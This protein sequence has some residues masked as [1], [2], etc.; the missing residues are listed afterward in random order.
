MTEPNSHP[1]WRPWRPLLTGEAAR[2][3]NAA[4]DAIAAELAASPES[5]KFRPPEGGGHFSLA[6][7]QA[8]IALFF[9]YLHFAR[10]DEGH[11]ETAMAFLEQAIEGTGEIAVSAGLYSGFAGVAWTLEHL[12]GRLFDP[13]GEDPGEEIATALQGLLG[14]SPWQGDYDL[15]SGLVGFGAYAL[16]RLPRPG[17]RECLEEI[18]SRLSELAESRETGTPPATGISWHTP[19]ERVGETQ[20]ELFPEGYYNLGVAHGV[21]GVI[22]L[23]GEVEAVGL[24]AAVTA[25]ARRLR[26]GA[27][28]WVASQQLP[29]G[30]NSL[31]PY[32]A[33]PGLTPTPSR[34]AWCYGDL[35]IAA[36]HLAAARAAR[37][38]RLETEAL[39]VARH[40]AARP[41]ESAGVV[42]AGLCHGAAGVGHLFNRLY[43]ASGEA[44]LRDAA[45]GWFERTLA[46]RGA[47]GIGGFR[48]WVPLDPDRTGE[49]GWATDP[50][51]LTG[52]AGIGLA[53]LAATT[54]VEPDWD[55]VL[56]T[57]IRG[58]SGRQE[59]T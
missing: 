5:A 3:A 35:G 56:L 33:A 38:P 2:A 12:Q 24:A 39:A 43:Q 52:S 34:L 29:A 7:G 13:D 42:D 50:G 16:E 15:I 59:E 26:E 58:A 46:L 8:G 18:V 27:A 11:D 31:F 30:A 47:E 32:S 51:F 55:R 36:A 28:A 23:L 9:A 21:P 1:T 54:A 6:G 17:G 37:D 44:A 22:G 4:V 19:P 53:L 41:A 45:R 10:P 57:A 48:A 40:A 25:E 14:R 49:L 20:R